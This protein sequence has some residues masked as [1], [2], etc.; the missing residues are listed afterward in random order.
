LAHWCPIFAEID[1][2][3]NLVFPFV[4]AIRND[5]LVLFEVVV[6]FFMQHC[7]LWFETY[8]SEPAHMLKTSV[9]TVLGKECP[10][11]L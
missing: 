7:Q 1:Y 6:S 3:P 5:D 9:E 11:L 2:I 10:A 4:K 8:P